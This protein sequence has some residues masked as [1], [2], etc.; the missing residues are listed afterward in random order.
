MQ[1]KHYRDYCISPKWKDV[2]NINDSLTADLK[3]RALQF[4]FYCQM[5]KGSN[6]NKIHNTQTSKHTL[7]STSYFQL[8]S[9]N[10]EGVG[11]IW[12]QKQ[13]SG[14]NHDFGCFR[15]HLKLLFS[16]NCWNWVIWKSDSLSQRGENSSHTTMW[17][18]IT[19]VVLTTA[20]SQS[21]SST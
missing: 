5:F 2:E 9:Q 17:L 3:K 10:K 7:S 16:L 18:S 14:R 12:L 4:M 19:S 11:N 8:A 20:L 15:S 6:L 13:S 1:S 21:A